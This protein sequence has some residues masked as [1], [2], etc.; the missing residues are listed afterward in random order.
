MPKIVIGIM[1]SLECC[2]NVV[3][4]VCPNLPRANGSNVTTSEPKV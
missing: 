4:T 2:D 3:V 1:N